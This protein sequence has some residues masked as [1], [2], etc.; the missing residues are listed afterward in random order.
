MLSVVIV[1]QLAINNKMIL[2]D[3]AWM[4]YIVV[5]VIMIEASLTF[6][7]IVEKMKQ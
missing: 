4:A 6:S 5:F 7:S 1:I 3:R 2:P